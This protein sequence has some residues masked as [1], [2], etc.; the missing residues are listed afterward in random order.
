MLNQLIKKPILS[1]SIIFVICSVA[2]LIEYFYMRTDETFL[3]ENFLHKLFG[4]LLLWGVLSICNLR[5]KDI[6]FSSD[7]TVSGIGKGLL[8]GLVCSVFAYAI[9][10]LTLF[11]LHRNVHLSF[12]ASGFSLTN[13]KGSQAGILFI[14]L[15]VLFN[16]INVWMEEGVFRGLFTKILEGI[17]YRRSLFFIAFLFGIWHLVMPFRDFL[18]GESSLT[19]LI[20]MGIGYVILAGMM[21]IKWSLLYKMTG[22]LWLG[23]GDHLFNNLASNLVHVVSNS[24]ADSLQIVRI[25]LWQLLSFATVVWVYK[26]QSKAIA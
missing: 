25:L 13:E 2:R 19:N 24:E 9:E 15:S 16:L 3:S 21:S 17:S 6:G 5:W 7:G 14:L 22:S 20:A 1:C 12:Y 18:Q 26:K 11:F 10:S 8:F 4:I 23:L